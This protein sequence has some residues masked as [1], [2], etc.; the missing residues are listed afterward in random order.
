MV[1]KEK[2]HQLMQWKESMWRI[3]NMEEEE[4]KGIYTCGCGKNMGFALIDACISWGLG[5]WD[6][7]SSCDFALNFMLLIKIK[8]PQK[9]VLTISL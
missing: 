4:T 2:E 6:S 8:K 3:I 9:H 7:R 1:R 5:L